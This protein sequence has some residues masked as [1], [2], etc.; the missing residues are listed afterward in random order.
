M[1]SHRVSSRSKNN[2]RIISRLLRPGMAALF[3]LSLTV[4]HITPSGCRTRRA[5]APF[6]SLSKRCDGPRVGR[7][8]HSERSRQPGV[9]RRWAWA[10]GTTTRFR[11]RLALPEELEIR[12]TILIILPP[13]DL[14]IRCRETSSPG[15]WYSLHFPAN[16]VKAQGLGDSIPLHRH[17]LALPE[18]LEVR[19][20][21]SPLSS[22]R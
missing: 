16:D 17:R 10:T 6:A 12:G 2:A 11:H 19:E 9:M 13:H 22:P 5:G 14:P 8:E 21:T 15:A 20:D 18:E 4:F 7:S 1:A 3:L